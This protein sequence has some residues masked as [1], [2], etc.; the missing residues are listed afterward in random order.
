MD[1]IPGSCVCV[2]FLTVRRSRMNIRTIKAVAITISG[3]FA[4]HLAAA[5]PPPTETIGQAVELPA[6]TGAYKVGTTVWHVTDKARPETFAGAGVQ[7]Q[8]EVLAWYPAA[9]A[10]SGGEPAPY[11]R[12]GL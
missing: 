3:L 9:P 11:L 12:E 8:V 2:A 6:P 5:A 1:R 7:R 4:A 10:A